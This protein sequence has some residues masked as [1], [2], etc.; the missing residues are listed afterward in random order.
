MP[1]L[2]PAEAGTR[3]E[4]SLTV[5]LE[6]V[7]EKS[8]SSITNATGNSLFYLLEKEVDIPNNQNEWEHHCSALLQCKCAAGFSPGLGWGIWAPERTGE[9][10]KNNLTIWLF[11]LWFI[12]VTGC[13]GLYVAPGAETPPKKWCFTANKVGINTRD[14]QNLFAVFH[15]RFPLSLPTSEFSWMYADQVGFNNVKDLVIK[16]LLKLCSPRAEHKHLMIRGFLAI[17][18]KHW[19]SKLEY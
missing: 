2:K 1:S 19:K 13:Q 6:G 16:L 4:V 17:C 7:R 18:V 14:W 15:S 9:K 10:M 3:N 8:S 11:N 5:Q 12:L